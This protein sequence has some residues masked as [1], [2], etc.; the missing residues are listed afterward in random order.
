VRAN[1]CSTAAIV[2]GE[3]AVPWLAERQV[4]A[5]LIGRGG[6]LATVGD[7]PQDQPSVAGERS[8]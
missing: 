7:W 8:C 4:A 6:G 3:R 5:R 2:L 1:T